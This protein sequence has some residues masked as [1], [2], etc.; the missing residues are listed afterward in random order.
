MKEKKSYYFV[1]VHYFLVTLSGVLN[2]YIQNK[3]GVNVQ[4]FDKKFKKK[5]DYK[6]IK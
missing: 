3:I 6:I 4:Q 1:K 5:D 2:S